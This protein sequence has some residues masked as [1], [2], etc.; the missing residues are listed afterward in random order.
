MA[1]SE[2]F[3][4]NLNLVKFDILDE[5]LL[6]KIFEEDSNKAFEKVC[7]PFFL[8]KFNLKVFQR[9]THYPRNIFNLLKIKLLLVFRQLLR[10]K[11]HVLHVQKFASQKE[12]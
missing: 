1:N 7:D 9:N 5:D 4:E 11:F 2:A 8:Y 6:D 10:R 3:Q 12:V